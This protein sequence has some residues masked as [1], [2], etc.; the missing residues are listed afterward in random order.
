MRIV[1]LHGFASSPQSSKARFFREKFRSRGIEIEIPALDGG[2]FEHL[3]VTSQLDIVTRTVGGQPAILMGSSLGG[4]LSALFAARHPSLVQK[5]VLLAPALDFPRRFRERYTEEELE[6]WRS[7][8]SAKVFHYGYGVEKDLSYG[9]VDDSRTY[10][11]NPDFP[12]PALI[13]HGGNDPVVP[14]QVS[15]AYRATHP[16][17]TLVVYD[18]G[19]ELTDVLDP[20]W[21]LT[22][23]F[24]LGPST[25]S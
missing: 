18:S 22:E 25:S 2:D 24:L 13:F 16:N 1:Y 12:H 10:E 23:E 11:N 8:G 17:V 21:T 6:G 14:V 4:Y 3:T 9:L 7:R 15:L 20:M 19:H 5:L